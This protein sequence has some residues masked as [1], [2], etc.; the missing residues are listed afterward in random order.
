MWLIYYYYSYYFFFFRFIFGALFL[1]FSVSV[2]LCFSFLSVINSF[3]YSSIGLLID[4][5]SLSL[6][7]FCLFVCLFVCY[8]FVSFFLRYI[9]FIC[10]QTK[11]FHSFS[12]FFHFFLSHPVLPFPYI[13][14]SHYSVDHFTLLH[15]CLYFF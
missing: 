9:F 6:S 11:F 10:T 4:F 5:L 14:S 8:F 3:I 2:C 15:V 13:Y 12:L 7:S 1:S